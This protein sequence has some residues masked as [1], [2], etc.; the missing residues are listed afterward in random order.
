[1]GP[2]RK[3]APGAQARKASGWPRG[4]V[5]GKARAMTA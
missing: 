3:A 1:M 2:G 4:G 5:I